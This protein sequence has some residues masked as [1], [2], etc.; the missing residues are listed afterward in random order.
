MSKYPTALSCSNLISL[1]GLRKGIFHISLI[2][3]NQFCV[4]HIR[5]KKPS[6]VAQAAPIDCRVSAVTQWHGKVRPN[7]VG[8]AT[9]SIQ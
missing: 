7:E 4:S 5:L 1:P 3:N 9:P 2:S 6:K 8:G